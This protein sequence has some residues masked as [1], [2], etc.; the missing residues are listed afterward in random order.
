MDTHPT[1][2]LE[3]VGIGPERQIRFVNGSA[4]FV[5]VIFAINGL[6][7]KDG[8]PVTAQTRGYAY[9]PKEERRL[10]QTPE[11]TPLPLCD[12]GVVEATIYEGSGHLPD[13]CH[14]TPLFVLRR[15][16]ARVRIRRISETPVVK[17]HA[18]Y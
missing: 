1:F 11:R 14:D 16:G 8:G 2:E 6:H 13:E 12:H 9:Y 10:F 18:L 4:N 17:I 3:V 15:I 7:A 5:E